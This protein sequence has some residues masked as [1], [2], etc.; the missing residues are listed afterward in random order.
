[1]I[2]DM[3]F[4]RNLWAESIKTTSQW[5]DTGREKT[6]AGIIIE[7]IE[8]GHRDARMGIGL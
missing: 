7:E 2:L 8:G 6:K 3:L 5:Q 4:S 1:M